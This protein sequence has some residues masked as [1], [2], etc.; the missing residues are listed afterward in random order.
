MSWDFLGSRKLSI[1]VFVMAMIYTLLL[2]VFSML[3][4]LPWVENISKL[5][6]YKFL[7]LLFFIN[8][9]ICEIKWIPVI[10]KRCRR[11]EMPRVAEDFAGFS[12]KVESSAGMTKLKSYVVRRGYSLRNSGENPS[13][14]GHY[15]FYASRGRFSPVGNIM[16]H[17]SFLL[18][19]AGI[20]L[21][22]LF[23]FE[24]NAKITEGYPFEGK[25]NDYANIGI[26]PLSS[27]PEISFE[28]KKITAEFWKDALL[29]TDL[30]ADVSYGEEKGTVLLSSPVTIGGA[31]I[32][33]Q[34]I[35]LTPLYLLKDKVGR[36]IDS[37][38]VNLNIFI[39]GSKDSFVIPGYPY[40]IEVSFYPDHEIKNEKIFNRSMN[41]ERP[42]YFIS[43]SK[44]DNLKEKPKVFSG[45]LRPEDDFYFDGLRLSFPEFIYWGSFRVVK[46]P[47]FIFIWISLAMMIAG[48][49]WRLLFY[50][51]EVLIEAF[52]EELT[53]YIYA[54]FFPKLFEEK[55]LSKLI[56]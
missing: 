15:L 20:S 22:I 4:P 30:R 37:A 54:D 16:F 10:I 2:V 14:G 17:F 7:Y 13:E 21:S 8:L 52:G 31:D 27:L 3:V 5:L 38:Y 6:P 35:G 24:G 45:S 46:D 55:I 41:P 9:I 25:R 43:V 42:A 11:P 23:R 49:I 40:R 36:V 33:L 12:H 18:I 29:F 50:R 53:V 44:L 1:F 48:L 28:L 19:L 39:P 32:T 47:G 34:G 51:R 26:A 56:T